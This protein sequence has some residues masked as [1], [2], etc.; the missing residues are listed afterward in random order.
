MKKVGIATMFGGANYGNALQNFAVHSLVEQCGYT[1]ITLQNN[2]VF[3]FKDYSWKNM[4]LSQKL[5]V[6]YIKAYLHNRLNARYGCKNDR[7]FRIVK[8]FY[9]NKQLN[10]YKKSLESRLKKFAMFRSKYLN[11]DTVP[12]TA[13]NYNEEHIDNFY[14]FVCGSDQVWNPYYQTTSSVDFLQFAQKHKRI[15]LAPS[16]GV[17]K[18]PDARKK[19]FANWLKEI[20][21]LSIREDA[22]AEIIKELTGISAPVLLDPTLC[23]TAE[24][25]SKLFKVPRHKPQKDFVFCYFLGNKNKKYCRY[26]KQYAEKNNC[27]IIDVFDVDDLRYYDSDP[28]EF[29]WLLSHAKAVFTDSFHGTAFSINL[30]V[31]FVVFD[32][33]EGG[34]SMFSRISTLLQKTDLTDRHYKKL[35]TADI[36]KISFLKSQSVLSAERQKELD[37][38]KNA[39]DSVQN[40]DSIYLT[41]NYHCTG[42]GACYNACPTGAISMLKDNEG[43]KYPQ[44]DNNKCINCHA[45]ENACPAD[46]I[47]VDNDLPKAYAA[48]SKDSAVQ[49]NSSSGGVFTHLANYILSLGGVVFGAAYDDDFKVC[50]VAIENQQELYKLRTSKYVQS[51]T[52]L[53]FKQAKEFLNAGRIV[54]FTGTPCQIAALK[55]YLKKDYDNLYTQDIICHGVP[56]PEAFEVYLNTYHKS[57][58]IKSISFRDKALGWN[59][60]SMKIEYADGTFY[61]ELATKDAFERAFLANLSL[62]PSCYQCQYKTASRISD[63]TLADYWGVELVHPELKEQQGVSLV[64]TH[65]PKGEKMLNHIVQDVDIISTDLKRALNYN[66]AALQSVACPPKR[67]TY[68]AEYK[69]TKMQPLVDRLLKPTLLQRLKRFIRKN[70]SRVK[71]LLRKIKG[72]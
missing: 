30:K 17:S 16:F 45:C 41:N 29:L 59:D 42:C 31:P 66:S 57:K 13:Q 27:E 54:L 56:S 8:L 34:N 40:A 7:D 11:I 69:Q 21:Y 47:T 22:G 12:I 3:G 37:F 63:I 48:Y 53:V 64:L 68:F 43:F 46:V 62:R 58:G 6:S 28:G 10:E 25:W 14:A 15:A 39:L 1:P 61:R 20:P 71:K 2:T 49:N 24:Q 36:D 23:I 44:I 9:Y 4:P 51:D 65:S 35:D 70:G 52:K 67:A 72:N 5:K 32:R 19:D 33:D 26:I 18:I 50:H 55:H 38:L 60:F